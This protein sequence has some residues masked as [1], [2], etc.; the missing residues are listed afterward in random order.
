VHLN[1]G[2]GRK[3]EHWL[4][5]FNVCGK[6]LRLMPV[7]IMHDDILGVTLLQSV[8]LLVGVDIEVE[9][10]EGCRMSLADTFSLLVR[11]TEV[12]GA[13]Q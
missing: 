3:H 13:G 9:G 5:F 4:Q 6:P 10:I 1:P 2:V 11:L 12:W 8:P 7:G